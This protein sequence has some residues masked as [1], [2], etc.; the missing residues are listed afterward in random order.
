MAEVRHY[1]HGWIRVGAD[2]KPVNEHSGT[3]LTKGVAAVAARTDPVGIKYGP[4][5]KEHSDAVHAEVSKLMAAGDHN[6]ASKVLDRHWYHVQPKTSYMPGPSVPSGRAA[7]SNAGSTA[8][9][10]TAPNM[11]APYNTSTVAPPKAK[12]AASSSSSSAHPHAP[13]GSPQGGQFVVASGSG[14][15]TASPQ[16]QATVKGVQK[17]LGL[18]P[19]GKVT[20]ADA[21]KIKAY[22]RK[23][24]L[25]VDGKVGAQTAAAILGKKATAP[26]TLKASDQKALAKVQHTVRSAALLYEHRVVADYEP[27]KLR[28]IEDYQRSYRTRA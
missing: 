20:P 23:H 26:G 6:T 24:G 11:N 4:G 14:G 16:Q 5:S 15:T 7:P 18:S 21:E 13:A 12:K 8:P 25:V 17:A 19:T 3:P 28:P 10:P 9:G 22:Q 27:L 2:G 1:M